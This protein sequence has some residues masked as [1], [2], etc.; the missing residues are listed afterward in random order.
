MISGSEHVYGGSGQ[1]DGFA[2][3][4]D[5]DYFVVAGA[6]GANNDCDLASP[7]PDI[8]NLGEFWVLKIRQSDYG[9]QWQ[10]IYH[11]DEPNTTPGAPENDLAWSIIIDHE[12]NYVVSGFCESCEEDNVNEKL[13]AMVVKIPSNGDD[14]EF[15]NDYGYK[16][17]TNSKDQGSYDLIEV[18]DESEPIPT[19]Y[20]VAAGITHPSDGGCGEQHDVY[21]LKTGTDGDAS[22]WSAGCQLDEGKDYGSTKKDDGRAA[23]QLCDGSFLIV[24]NVRFNNGDVSC[25]VSNN[26][27]DIWLV[28]IEADGT[29]DWDLTLG[30]SYADIAYSV[31][32]VPDGSI[33]IAG[34]W[35]YSAIITD[36]Y[37]AIVELTCNEPVLLAPQNTAN[38]AVE[39]SWEENPCAKS[40]DLR[41][42]KTGP[43]PFPW[44]NQ[45]NV[46]SPYTVTGLDASWNGYYEWEVRARCSPG[47]ITS[48]VHSSE[49]FSLSSCRIGQQEET[50]SDRDVVLLVYPNPAGEQL[51]VFIDFKEEI[52]SPAIVEILDQVG[53]IVF[54]TSTEV[55]S[56][57]LEKQL[58]VN[59]LPSGF[60]S[61]RLIIANRQYYSKF[62]KQ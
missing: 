51:R 26:V 15:N 37:V 1:E 16:T 7:V 24:G 2:V 29:K 32:Q 54:A 53:R 44:T 59:N 34:Q 19:Y 43:I 42:R 5:G 25:I 57:Q 17:T 28:N 31:A 20:Y 45:S 8:N 41:Y 9:I 10:R 48:F 56:G 6:T 49:N 12:G 61:I 36:F 62:A 13:Q 4:V 22:E 27:D 47:K 55:Q 33:L 11:G 38:C 3:K 40:Y 60:Y 46:T 52:F 39:L 23:I 30:T 35:G 18:Y 58:S 21:V 14:P 50:A